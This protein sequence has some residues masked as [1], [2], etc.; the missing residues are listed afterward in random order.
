MNMP[1]NSDYLLT[2]ECFSQKL[3]KSISGKLR[4]LRKRKTIFFLVRIT[5][6][7]QDSSDEQF[8]IS[9]VG[10]LLHDSRS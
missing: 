6:I 3:L 2:T 1:N 9:P 5:S 10:L 8:L 7:F 4:S